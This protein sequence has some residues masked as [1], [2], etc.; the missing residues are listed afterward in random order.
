MGFIFLAGVNVLAFYLTPVYKQAEA[1]EA[2]AQAPL[3]AKIIAGM[4]LFLWFGV[5]YLGRMLPFLGGAF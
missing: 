4:S 1:V 3:A 5:M 2:G